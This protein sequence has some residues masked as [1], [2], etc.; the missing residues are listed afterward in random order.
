MSKG[1]LQ[2]S[3]HYAEEEAFEE[4]D[5]NDL[6]NIH[7]LSN[8]KDR[9][10]FNAKLSVDGK[11]MLFELDTGASLSSISLKDFQ[12]NFPNKKLLS[13]AVE[14]RTYTGEIIKPCGVAFV[15][16]NYKGQRFIGKLYVI[17]HQVDAIFGREWMREVKLDW[18]DMRAVEETNGSQLTSLLE[19]YEDIFKTEIGEIPDFKA[20]FQVM[21]NTIPIYIKPRQVPYAI[22]C[23]VEREIER[24]EREHIITKVENSA[25]GTPVVPVIKPNGNVRLCA[26][27]KVTLNKVIEEVNY[28]IPRIE[29]IFS[30]MSGGKY[31]CTLDISNAYLH[32]VMDDESAKMQTLSTHKG[33]FKVNRLMFGV[34]VAPSLWQR[35]MDSTLQGLDGVQCFFDD[36]LVQGSTF[37][38]TL[39]RLKQVLNVLRSKNLRLNREKCKFFQKSI[40][41]LGHVIDNNGLHKSTEKVE[42]ITNAKRPSNINELRSFLG[43]VT[44]YSKFISCF[45]DIVYPL[46][47]LLKKNKPF[48]W[49]SPCEQSFK[50]VKEEIANE[51]TLAHFDPSLPL[52]LATDASP[53]GLGA[54]LSHRMK[55]GSERPIDQLDQKTNKLHAFLI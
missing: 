3:V 39:Q 34:K 7:L 20:K 24:L 12:H 14:L 17:D 1:K 44:Y 6:H 8:S 13:T 11:E 48:K 45:S 53:V 26:D 49:T 46:N 2:K 30:N 28:P 32:M 4:E 38:E 29:D 41:Y 37:D 31:F 50:K 36:I 16:C 15:K 25:W 52:V 35:F 18:A 54:V 33:L 22:K 19:E 9:G 47:N 51:R 55:D 43:L 5:G 27:Y 10:K 23:K 42:A 40:K 21:E